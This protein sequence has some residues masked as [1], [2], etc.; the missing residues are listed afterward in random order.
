MRTTPVRVCSH[1][2]FKWIQAISFPSVIKTPFPLTERDRQFELDQAM[3]NL[4]WWF[5]NTN[6][7]RH[8]WCL[9]TFYSVCFGQRLARWRS[10][11]FPSGLLEPSRDECDLWTEKES[12]RGNVLLFVQSN[13]ILFPSIKNAAVNMP[14][15]FGLDRQLPAYPPWL[16]WGRDWERRWAAPSGSLVCL[17]IFLSSLFA[18]VHSL[19]YSVAVSP[20]FPP[21]SHSLLPSLCCIFAVSSLSPM[22]FLNLKQ[23]ASG[24]PG[25]KF[26]P[27]QRWSFFLSHVCGVSVF[28]TNT[29][30]WVFL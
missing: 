28:H 7:P 12:G 14:P 19:L 25:I 9:N 1:K 23:S 2:H 29:N 16:V 15:Y 26:L 5:S 8:F 10:S 4:A 17:W 20:S 22:F 11:P 30:R 6:F 3:L 13:I 18:Y 24:Y 21:D 27:D